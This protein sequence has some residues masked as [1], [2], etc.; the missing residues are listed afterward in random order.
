MD[1]NIKSELEFWIKKLEANDFAV[2]NVASQF[3]PKLLAG[4]TARRSHFLFD[5]KFIRVYLIKT[6]DI[7]KELFI[8]LL[9][10]RGVCN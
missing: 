7:K 5:D 1:G 4:T 8:S 3:D 10:N 6:R 9:D 2:R